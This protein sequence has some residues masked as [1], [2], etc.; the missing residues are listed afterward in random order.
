[1]GQHLLDPRH[2]SNSIRNL[3]QEMHLRKTFELSRLRLNRS[4]SHTRRLHLHQLLTRSPHLLQRLQTTRTRI[5]SAQ[6][7]QHLADL[8]TN[9][10][11]L[12]RRSPLMRPRP[13]LPGQKIAHRHPI[14]Q[15]SRMVEVAVVEDEAGDRS[16]ARSE[17]EVVSTTRE[18]DINH[19]PT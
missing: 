11:K 9:S 19:R 13:N 7:L 14:R 1:M 16:M 17:A 10:T 15:C 18:A 3:S 2:I 8:H 12:T 6:L 5:K 4:L